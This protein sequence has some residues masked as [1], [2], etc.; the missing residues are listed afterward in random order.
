L[1]LNRDDDT[2][3]AIRK[4]IHKEIFSNQKLTKQTQKE[5]SMLDTSHNDIA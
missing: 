2:G 5:P 4:H 3:E 1:R